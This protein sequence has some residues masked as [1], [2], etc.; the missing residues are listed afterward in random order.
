MSGIGVGA[1]IND[2]D[3]KSKAELRN[4]LRDHPETVEFYATAAFGEDA[5]K[6][7]KGNELPEGR[8]LD[9]T[10]PNPYTARNWWANVERNPEN[11]LRFDGKKIPAAKPAADAGDGTPGGVKLTGLSSLQVEALRETMNTYELGT[12]TLT[13]STA[14]FHGGAAAALTMLEEVKTRAAAEYGGTG[15]PARTLNTPIRRLREITNAA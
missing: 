15:H 9:V 12:V 10:G 2:R 7:F 6:R 8:R 3:P 5:G 4:A 14:V 1:T 13:A 11:G